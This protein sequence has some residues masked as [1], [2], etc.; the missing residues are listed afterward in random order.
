MNCKT[1]SNICL[2]YWYTQAPN[3]QHIVGSLLGKVERGDEKVSDVQYMGCSLAWG[4]IVLI[5]ACFGLCLKQ[6]TYTWLGW[7]HA[8]FSDQASL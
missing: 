3:N 6:K 7:C 8:Q 4:S 1:F 5:L 2:Y